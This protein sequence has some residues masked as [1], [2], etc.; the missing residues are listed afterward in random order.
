MGNARRGLERQFLFIGGV[1][2]STNQVWCIRS[3]N[4]KNGAVTPTFDQ[5][6]AV[7]LGGTFGFSQNINPEGLVGQL[8][9]AVDRSGTSTNNN[10]YMMASVRPTGATNGAD[11]MFVRSTNGG[12]TFSAP[13][14]VNDDPIN[15]SKWH[16]F[17][18]FAVAPNGR[19]DSVWLDTRNAANNTDSQLFYSYSLDAGVTW[20]PNVAGEQFV[21]SV[22]RLS[23]PEQDGRL[24]YHGFRQ[25]RSRCRVCR[26]VQ[27]RRRHLLR[28]RRSSGAYP[29][30]L[31][32]HRTAYSYPHPNSN[33]TPTP[34]LRTH[35]PRPPA[36]TPTPTPS[37][38]RRRASH[39]NPL[40]QLRPR[41]RLRRSTSRLGCEF[42][43][44]ITS[45]SAG[46]S[47]PGTPRHVLLRAIG[48]SI[49]G[50]FR[51]AR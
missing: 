29:T 38:R 31:T 15:P 11:V 16:W 10:I 32:P 45:A 28:S 9:L 1:N 6:T 41:L 47:S 36:A 3:S 19:L 26:H 22:P 43:P 20:S 12:L 35:Q 14:R 17:G 34:P 13:K 33:S 25:Y 48:P 30:H 18:T 8:F 2:T 39:R 27:S 21:Q 42:K 7:N 50:C 23:E 44:V 24:H 49:I 4:A 37:P 46:S 40:H 5:S 51:C